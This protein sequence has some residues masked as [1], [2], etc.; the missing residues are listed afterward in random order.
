MLMFSQGGLGGAVYEAG[1][2][3]QG[4]DGPIRGIS[5]V[6]ETEDREGRNA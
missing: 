3:S 2:E 4:L 5:V 6:E 1:G